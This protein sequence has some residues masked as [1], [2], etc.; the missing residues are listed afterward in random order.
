[1]KCKSKISQVIISRVKMSRNWVKFPQVEYESSRI[2]VQYAV[3]RSLGI[4]F[5]K[6][7]I[8]R[9]HILRCTPTNL[10]KLLGS[11]TVKKFH[12]RKNMR[13]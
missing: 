11:I 13:C 2:G 12:I 7:K 3:F 6:E 5:L 10:N 9:D 1:M 8:R 4:N